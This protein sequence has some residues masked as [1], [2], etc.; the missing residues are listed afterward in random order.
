MLIDA[1]RV[2]GNGSSVLVEPER[3]R[4][5]STLSAPVDA[6]DD[7]TVKAR[8]EALREGCLTVHCCPLCSR[9][10]TASLLKRHAAM[11]ASEHRGI[12]HARKR[13]LA[14]A[15]RSRRG[16]GRSTR[17]VG[18]LRLSLRATR[19]STAGSELHWVAHIRRRRRRGPAGNLASARPHV[20]GWRQRIANRARICERV[21]VLFPF[22]STWT[23][24][25]GPARR[26]VTDRYGKQGMQNRNV[27]RETCAQR[28]M[29]HTC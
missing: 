17:A 6:A 5:R 25:M 20:P 21:L 19:G 8:C 26:F 22:Q 14:R 15:L 1:L 13:A 16:A 23:I 12:A 7:H 29:R 10:R 2:A 11:P 4:S 9:V 3:R 27:R 18:R 28:C 24:D